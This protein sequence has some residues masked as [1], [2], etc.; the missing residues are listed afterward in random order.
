MDHGF[1][2]ICFCQFRWCW[3]GDVRSICTKPHRK[4]IWDNMFS[5]GSQRPLLIYV[6]RLVLATC[7]ASLTR[8]YALNVSSSFVAEDKESCLRIRKVYGSEVDVSA[9]LAALKATTAEEEASSFEQ[10]S[11]IQSPMAPIHCA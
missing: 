9:K 11:S 1:K 6:G 5:R 10:C 2:L 8:L 7:M 4:S 3:R